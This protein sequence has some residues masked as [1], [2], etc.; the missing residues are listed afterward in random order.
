MR[1]SLPLPGLV[2]FLCMCLPSPGI[3]AGRPPVLAQD[4]RPAPEAEDEAEP[5]GTAFRSFDNFDIEGGDFRTLRDV[6]AGDCL[7]ACRADERCRAFTFNKWN[8]RC[9]LKERL[10]ELRLEPSSITGLRSNVPAPPRLRSEITMT[11]Y[12][13]RL[14][15]GAAYATRRTDSFGTCEALC[16]EDPKCAVFS[17]LKASRECRLLARAREYV[18][19]ERA[20]SGAKRQ[21]LR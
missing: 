15:P 11:P 2:L 16:A 3:P 4:A 18:P 8:H 19:D 1:R 20:D 9:F 7:A 14:F 10:S 12:R 21:V 6:D 13:N 17:F 5:S